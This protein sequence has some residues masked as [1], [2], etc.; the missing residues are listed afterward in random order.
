MELTPPRDRIELDTFCDGNSNL[1]ERRP[2]GLVEFKSL[3]KRKKEIPSV[4]EVGDR[5]VYKDSEKGPKDSL[6]TYDAF[7][8]MWL[9]L[10]STVALSFPPIDIDDA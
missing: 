9:Q 5:C 7:E 8:A 6:H 1:V 2:K 3:Q 10:L 4:S